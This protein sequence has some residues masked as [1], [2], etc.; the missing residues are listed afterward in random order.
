MVFIIVDFP[1]PL[2]PMMATNSPRLTRNDTLRM[3]CTSTSPVTYTFL[4]L[5]S[6]MIGVSFAQVRPGIDRRNAHLVH[7]AAH[8]IARNRTKLRLEQHLEPPRPIEGVGSKQ[9]VDAMFDGNFTGRWRHRLI[10][11]MRPANAEQV[12]LR[13]HGQRVHRALDQ[14]SSDPIREAGS[15]FFSQ[16]SWVVSR[17]ISA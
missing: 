14:R 17:P 13:S 16:V 3:A 6:A 9:L 4:M 11:E 7:I 12:R 15:F 1:E 8:G 5:S 2:A 10:I